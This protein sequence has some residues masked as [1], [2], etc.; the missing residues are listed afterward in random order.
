MMAWA[1]HVSM[2]LLLSVVLTVKTSVSLQNVLLS[3]T[4]FSIGR[5]VEFTVPVT[6]RIMQFLFIVRLL[7]TFVLLKLSTVQDSPSMHSRC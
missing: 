1:M 2:V 5:V 6:I 7:Y 4:W 3:Q